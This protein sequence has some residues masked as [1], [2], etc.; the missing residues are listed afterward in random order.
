[1]ATTQPKVRNRFQTVRCPIEIQGES[2]TQ[3]H[4]ADECDINYIVNRF[5]KTGVVTHLATTAQQFMEIDPITL[6]EALNQ[7]IE[8]QESFDSLPSK[9]R[10]AFGNDP[11]EFLNAVHDPNSK[12]KLIELGLIAAPVTEE[13]PSEG[14][15]A[16]TPTA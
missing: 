9:V 14:V 11:M 4:F 10:Q 5:N 3:Q 16:E 15:G 2:R 6:Q 8:A 7:S 1:M 13:V 12:D